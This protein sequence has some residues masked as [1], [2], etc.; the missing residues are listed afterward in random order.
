[1]QSRREGALISESRKEEELQQGNP[2][3]QSRSDLSSAEGPAVVRK[4]KTCYDRRKVSLQTQ[5]ELWI[6][7]WEDEH[8]DSSVK[9]VAS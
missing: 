7:L 5:E 2:E 4:E 9:Y 3:E 6:Q 8:F 1:M